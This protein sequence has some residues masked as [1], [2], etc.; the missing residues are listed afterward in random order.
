MTRHPATL[1]FLA[2]VV[3]IGVF[4]LMDAAMKSASLLTGVYTAVLMRNWLGTALAM[5]V[6]VLGKRG[7]IAGNVMRIHALRGAIVATMA[8]LFFFGLTRIPMAEAIALSFIA[9]L[10][11]LYLAS[12]WLGER[13]R[14][15]AII[16]SLLGLAG[17]V[18]I[19]AARLG[20]GGYDDHAMT[21]IAAILASAV[22]YAVNLVIQRRQALL[23][24]PVEIAAFQ[25]LF[26]GLFLLPFAPWLAV[27]PEPAA[28][29]DIA[30]GAVL[31]TT[32]LLLLSWGYA[33]AEAQ[34]LLP[35]EYTAFL[36]AAL[37][38]WLW[39]GETVD[40]AVVAGAVLIV[41]GC[42]VAARR[43]VAPAVP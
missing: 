43:P 12:L 35:V 6:W 19:A 29:R 30:L 8:P 5:P 27:W 3:G 17:V 31:A 10:I 4:S 26:V 20:Q 9:P 2:V 39:F 33:R 34:V 7:P 22:A 1:P 14:P 25:N 42:L 41:A 21:G 28:W 37:L 23:A 36:W 32:A 24:G 11:A 13:I 18:V 38:G 16:A 15:D 40:A